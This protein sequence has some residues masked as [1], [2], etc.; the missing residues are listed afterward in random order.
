VVGQ[1]A[2]PV[3][4][5]GSGVHGVA[6]P[7]DDDAVAGGDDPDAFG[8]MEGLPDAVAVPGGAGTGGEPETVRPHP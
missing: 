2:V 6:G 1:G 4:L 8:D 5:P 7:H 3:L